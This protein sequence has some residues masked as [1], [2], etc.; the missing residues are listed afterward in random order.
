MGSAYIPRALQAQMSKEGYN[1]GGAPQV[2][3]WARRSALLQDFNLEQQA[4][5]VA[6]YWRLQNGLKPH[7]GPA[8]PADLPFY[9]YFVDQL[10]C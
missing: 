6:D 5:L 9:A 10:K 8:G 1:Y 4:D 3:N 2:V 7:W